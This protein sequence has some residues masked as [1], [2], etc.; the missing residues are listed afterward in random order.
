MG[1]KIGLGGFGGLK[2][3]ILFI[4]GLRKVLHLTILLGSNSFNS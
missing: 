2:P 4:K 3:K 1:P